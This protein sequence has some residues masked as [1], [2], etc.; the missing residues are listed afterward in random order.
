AFTLIL[1]FVSDEGD[2]KSGWQ[3]VHDFIDAELTRLAE[4]EAGALVLTT[5]AGNLLGAKSRV[6]TT[7]GM[8]KVA[9]IAL[10]M[11]CKCPGLLRHYSIHNA[12]LALTAFRRYGQRKPYDALRTLVVAATEKE[13]ATFDEFGVG[14]AICDSEVCWRCSDTIL[15]MPVSANGG[16]VE[17]DGASCGSY[18]DA[19]GGCEDLSVPTWA[20]GV[21][22]LGER[23]RDNRVQERQGAPR[24]RLFSSLTLTLSKGSEM[25]SPAVSD[26]SSGSNSCGETAVT[27]VGTRQ[28]GFGAL[29][30]ATTKE[31][32]SCTQKAA[33]SPPSDASAVEGAAWPEFWDE[34]NANGNIYGYGCVP[35][36]SGTVH[37]PDAVLDRF[38]APPSPSSAA[39]VSAVA[40]RS[41]KRDGGELRQHR[42]QQ[43]QTQQSLLPK[44]RGGRFNRPSSDAWVANHRQQQQQQQQQQRQ[45]N[46]DTPPARM[47][48]ATGLGHVVV[49]SA[50][51]H[52]KGAVGGPAAAPRPSYRNAPSDLRSGIEQQMRGGGGGG[53]GGDGQRD[54]MQFGDP[55]GRDSWGRAS[56]VAGEGRGG[57]RDAESVVGGYSSLTPPQLHEASR[58]PAP[59]SSGGVGLVLAPLG[60][61]GAIKHQ[62]QHQQQQQQ[63]QQEE[64]QHNSFQ[65]SFWRIQG[66]EQ[67]ALL[68]TLPPPLNAA[69]ARA[70]VNGNARYLT[71]R[72]GG[73]GEEMMGRNVGGRGG[74]GGGG[75]GA[76]GGGVARASIT[77][78]ASGVGN[79]QFRQYHNLQ[80]LTEDAGLAEGIDANGTNHRSWGT[81]CGGD[82]GQA[83]GGGG[84]A[85]FS[86]LVGMLLDD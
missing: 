42:H 48:L 37:D 86:E 23:G 20:G 3:H 59:S 69:S 5:L 17:E 55:I 19:D 38:S 76:G 58:H 52:R 44:E 22:T 28:G 70:F 30:L 36:P 8:L 10:S 83:S 7:E 35:G 27:R 79:D 24:P 1:R 2:T 13:I 32:I 75:G 12:H 50:G 71:E 66:V 43:Q 49:S 4:L 9:E 39:V 84:G 54:E 31:E 51:A 45:G 25:C 11:F 62:Q 15:E 67:D 40:R 18:V 57:R 14:I 78:D 26:S 80:Q 82:E 77:S 21:K 60:T 72:R 74:G 47:A 85:V 68:N 64:G 16:H 73:A 46:S 41:V 56:G 81:V 29:A 33:V 61:E 6:G 63:Q 53:G 34:S 65:P